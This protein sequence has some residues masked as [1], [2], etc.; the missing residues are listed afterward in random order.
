VAPGGA[1]ESAQPLHSPDRGRRPGEPTQG[2]RYRRRLELVLDLPPRPRQRH[3]LDTIQ[4]VT[5]AGLLGEGAVDQ[6]D[7]TEWNANLSQGADRP[8]ECCPGR[9][10]IV[11]DQDQPSAS[12]GA[13]QGHPSS[14]TERPP[15]TNGNGRDVGVAETVQRAGTDW[16]QVAARSSDAQHGQRSRPLGPAPAELDH[17]G[18]DVGRTL[19]EAREARGQ[20]D[21]VCPE[22]GGRADL[23]SQGGGSLDQRDGPLLTGAVR[24]EGSGAQLAG[25]PPHAVRDA[26]EAATRGCCR[27]GPQLGPDGRG[28]GGCS[29]P[30][31]RRGTIAEV[32]GDA[33]QG[34]AVALNLVLDQLVEPGG[35]KK[36]VEPVPGGHLPRD[37]IKKGG[38][39]VEQVEE[40]QVRRSMLAHSTRRSRPVVAVRLKARGAQC[41]AHRRGPRGEG[42]ERRG[43]AVTG[44]L[45][46]VL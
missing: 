35:Q 32:T 4:A 44:R 6:H 5:Q 41:R 36:G 42:A 28:G 33:V 34:P 8:G 21:D 27:S 3:P 43:P 12:H 9:G 19:V 1:G 37:E 25:Q 39:I 24:L 31:R 26:G 14:R 10:G 7:R 40:H 45:R 38:E 46:R 2:R 11:E 20:A 23:A 15:R 17:Q 18:P 30:R 16:R 29:P 13:A 22:L